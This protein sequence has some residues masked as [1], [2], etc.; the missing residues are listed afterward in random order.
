VIT[1]R[2]SLV[3]GVLANLSGQPLT[4]LPRVAD[5]RFVTVTKSSFSKFLRNRTPCITLSSR[6]GDSQS[7]KLAFTFENL[8]EF[9]HTSLQRRVLEQ[10]I[11]NEEEI[12]RVVAQVLSSPPYLALLGSW[13]GLWHLV[14]SL[15]LEPRV[16]V[17]VFDISQ[18]ELMKDF[19][20]QTDIEASQIFRKVYDEEIGTLGGEP[21]SCL[22]GDYYLT[23]RPEDLS[24][25]YH[26]SELAA[27]AGAPFLC[28]VEP[29]F[30][31]H[32]QWHDL[33]PTFCPDWF[34]GAS[35]S[36]EWEAFR[37]SQ[38]AR[39]VFPVLPRFAVDAGYDGQVVTQVW[40]NSAYLVGSAIG[41]AAEKIDQISSTGAFSADL[42]QF[43]HGPRADSMI[44]GRGTASVRFE[45]ECSIEAQQSLSRIGF[46][47]LTD[48]ITLS[49][50]FLE[51]LIAADRFSQT[52]GWSFF[53]CL[54]WSSVLHRLIQQ[55][56]KYRDDCATAV[57]GLR[58]H[59]QG[60]I[61]GG[62]AVPGGL[63]ILD[64]QR[65]RILPVPAPKRS[66]ETPAPEL[67]LDPRSMRRLGKR[68]R[69]V[70]MADWI[71]KG[72]K[73][74]F[75]PFYRKPEPVTDT[76][77]D[78][79]VRKLAPQPIPFRVSRLKGDRVD[80]QH[81]AEFRCIDDFLPE[82]VGRKVADLK[83]LL[84]RRSELVALAQY[85]DSLAGCSHRLG[86]VATRRGEIQALGW[87][88]EGLVVAAKEDYAPIERSAIELALP[89]VFPQTWI[90]EQARRE[91]L[92]RGL[93]AY[94][95]LK[96][97]QHKAL[98]Q[99]A[100]EDL[101]RVLNDLDRRVSA[102]LQSVYR[103][104]AYREVEGRWRAVQWLVHEFTLTEDISMSLSQVEFDSLAE[105]ARDTRKS[106]VQALQEAAP[107]DV[108][109][110]LTVVVVDY[111]LKP[112]GWSARALARAFSGVRAQET[113][114]I[115]RLDESMIEEGRLEQ[116]AFQDLVNSE[117]AN[118]LILVV[119]EFR[120]RTGY[121][122]VGKHPA[123]FEFGRGFD[124]A[125]DE[126]LSASAVYLALGALA[127]GRGELL[128]S[129]GRLSKDTLTNVALGFGMKCSS[130]GKATVIRAPNSHT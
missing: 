30:L 28:G 3:I 116:R 44:E 45:W 62:F 77:L 60:N 85:V 127:K 14:E 73:E 117:A 11:G 107:Q 122:A 61:A 74:N 124:S 86:K 84:D 129:R 1:E 20:K 94:A 106:F 10:G 33:N 63:L 48:V 15:A 24:L 80:P 123:F 87:K 5:R 89:D 34:Q 57:E 96:T 115:C 25:L 31:N 53:R 105:Y 93:V 21:F 69:L 83:Q 100:I 65:M 128:D 52:I 8:Q 12:E 126:D 19:T 110:C 95:E 2:P 71:G 64:G 18:R 59:F 50:D 72:R 49:M 70:V 6:S 97:D 82:R 118:E 108:P 47:A 99:S 120:V 9:S 23:N 40:V 103:D 121:A 17:K 68:V 91:D 32:S 51:K 54:A 78:D 58:E 125:I 55:Q 36:A 112:R 42:G 88:I 37:R 75:L 98:V 29:S 39:Y 4:P 114:V 26:I 67:S 76:N 22:I 38:N 81:E 66:R 102:G 43:G 92:L 101:S 27:I 111:P 46:N 35:C 113:I 41:A 13:A 56:L 109:G 104:S 7:Q 79:V 16:R 119:G 90:F 130:L